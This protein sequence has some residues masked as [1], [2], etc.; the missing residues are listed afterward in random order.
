MNIEKL[1]LSGGAIFICLVLSSCSQV[2]DASESVSGPSSCRNFDLKNTKAS[3]EKKELMSVRKMRD[4]YLDCAIKNN[5]ADV[6]YWG[7]I[8]AEIGTNE[9]KETYSSLQM[10]YN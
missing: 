7:K 6:M 2:N 4:Y 10:T 3:A 9:D 8:A 1:L 5:K